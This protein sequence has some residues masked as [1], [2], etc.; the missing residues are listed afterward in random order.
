MVYMNKDDSPQPG[1]ERRPSHPELNTGTGTQ[2]EELI[3][4]FF[5]GQVEN[6]FEARMGVVDPPLVDHVSAILAEF[7]RTDNMYAL[8]SVRGQRLT[9][10]TDMLEEARQREG[11]AKAKVHLHIGK[12][13]LFLEGYLPETAEFIR[14]TTKDYLIDYKQQGKRSYWIAS[15][16]PTSDVDPHSNVDPEVLKGLSNQYELCCYGLGEVRKGI[17]ENGGLHR[18]LLF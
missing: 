16:L 5:R 4:R 2:R 7:V 9:T 13:T 12:L 8:R 18:L 10:V 3:K 15:T 6:T 14:K 17:E 1:P 11:V